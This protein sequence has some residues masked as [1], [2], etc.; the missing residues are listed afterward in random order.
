MNILLCLCG[1]G[2]LN[3]CMECV[4]DCS[5]GS[6]LQQTDLQTFIHTLQAFSKTVLP[7][8]IHTLQAF[9]KMSYQH[10]SIHSRHSARLSCQHSSGHSRHSARCPTNIHPG[11]PGI[12][13]DVLPTFIHTLQAF[14][15][16][17]MPT[18]IRTLQAFGKMSYQHSS[19][20]SRHSARCP[21]NI[22][23]DTTPGI[24]QTATG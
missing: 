6:R 8:F 22:H 2:L 17:V 7:A 1:C 12:Q 14:S 9:S 11:T 10:T 5:Q 18:F 23:P 13:Q 4:E 21:A 3:A 20:H 24:Q 16:T 19:R 15:K